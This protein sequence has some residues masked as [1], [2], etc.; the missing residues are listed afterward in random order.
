MSGTEVEDW[1]N[2]SLKPEYIAQKM[3]MA[4]GFLLGLLIKY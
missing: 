3:F 4:P 2:E 1:G